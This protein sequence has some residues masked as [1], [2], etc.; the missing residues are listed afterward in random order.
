MRFRKPRQVGDL[1]LSAAVNLPDVGSGNWLTPFV[2]HHLWGYCHFAKTRRLHRPTQV[3]ELSFEHAVAASARRSAR[4]LGLMTQIRTDQAQTASPRAARRFSRRISCPRK[5]VPNL[6]DTA[7]RTSPPAD[8]GAISL[9]VSS[10]H[11]R[12]AFAPGVQEELEVVA[13]L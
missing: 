6:G 2:C 12:V 13:I 3:G 4:T 9:T 8:A 10:R 5:R 1:R 11:L 7:R